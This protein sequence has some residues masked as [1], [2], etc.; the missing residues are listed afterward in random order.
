MDKASPATPGL[1]DVGEGRFEM[2]GPMGFENAAR[3]LHES[4][5]M[6]EDHT[7]IQVDLAGVGETD[8]AGLALLLEWINWANHSVREIR[9]LNIPDRIRCIARTSDVEDLLSFGERWT[10]FIESTV[11][12]EE[13]PI[14]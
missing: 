13:T 8:T 6:F 2:H 9:F 7:E 1:R 3:L 12:D 11:L 5:V 14:G 4:H 10:G